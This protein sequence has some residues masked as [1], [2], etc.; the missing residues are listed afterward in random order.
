MP[1][2]SALALQA[3]ITFYSPVPK[4]QPIP[5]TAQSSSMASKRPLN[6]LLACL[7]EV[8]TGVWPFAASLLAFTFSRSI[9]GVTTRPISSA[10]SPI[11][12][13]PFGAKQSSTARDRQYIPRRPAQLSKHEVDCVSTRNATQRHAS[14]V[15]VITYPSPSCTRLRQVLKSNRRRRC[16]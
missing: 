15:N 1:V 13:R 9:A 2:Q 8:R 16:E 7:V 14:S 10:D 4:S 12:R 3:C 11:L 5:R 6:R